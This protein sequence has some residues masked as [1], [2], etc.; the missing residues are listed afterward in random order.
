VA[1]RLSL[2]PRTA[3]GRVSSRLLFFA[4]AFRHDGAFGG[5]GFAGGTGFSGPLSHIKIFIEA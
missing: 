2:E 4:G 3:P 1:A 5:T